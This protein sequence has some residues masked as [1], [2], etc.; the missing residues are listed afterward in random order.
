MVPILCILV[1]KLIL[2]DSVLELLDTVLGMAFTFVIVLAV[3]LGV[4]NAPK[5]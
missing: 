3:I 1:L 4:A 2:P 5:K